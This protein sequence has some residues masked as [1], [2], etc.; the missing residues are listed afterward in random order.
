MGIEI[1]YKVENGFKAKTTSRNFTLRTIYFIVGYILYN[2][3]IIA[4]VE[5]IKHKKMTAYI[6]RKTIEELIK[7]KVSGLGPPQ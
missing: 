2:I 7:G 6:F 3:W 4:R 5:T 1:S